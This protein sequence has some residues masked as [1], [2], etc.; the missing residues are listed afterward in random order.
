MPRFSSG[1]GRGAAALLIAALI[2]AAGCSAASIESKSSARPSSGDY[3]LAPSAPDY[4]L[5]PTYPL[6]SP[7]P[8]FYPDETVE[9]DYTLAPTDDTTETPTPKPPSVELTMGDL[10]GVCASFPAAGAAPYN[11]GRS[12]PVVVVDA[13]IPSLN[14]TYDI[15]SSWFASSWAS[16]IQLVACVGPDGRKSAG[17]CGTYKRQSDGKIGSLI[18]YKHS[19]TITVYVARTGKKLQTKVLYG[20]VPTATRPSRYRW[21][22]RRLGASTAAWS[23]MRPSMPTPWRSASSSPS[24]RGAPAEDRTPAA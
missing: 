19:R 14:S 12:H 15:N 17:S 18:K 23:R 20:P 3:T 22:P 10:V 11:K 7:D 5:R 16:P 6:Y 8:P 9:P 1:A 24:G 21:A 4:T 13:T 2:V